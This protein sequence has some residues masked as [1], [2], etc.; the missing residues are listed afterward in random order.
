MLAEAAIVRTLDKRPQAE[1]SGPRH[2]RTS[3][4]R[5]R[6][7]V[8]LV[9]CRSGREAKALVIADG[10]FRTKTG[11]AFIRTGTYRNRGGRHRVHTRRVNN[12][13][14]QAKHT[15]VGSNLQCSRLRPPRCKRSCSACAA[16]P[17][18]P[19]ERTGDPCSRRGARAGVCSG[20]MAGS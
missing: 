14:R 1:E 16:E 19:P 3:V 15:R 8:P 17:H 20:G 9:T 4:A 2:S 7:P 6:A 13:E 10:V 18:R 5:S 11:P 12:H